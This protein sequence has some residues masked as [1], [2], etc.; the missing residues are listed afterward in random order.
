MSPPGP[1]LDLDRPGLEGNLV[2]DGQFRD[3]AG[4]LSATYSDGLYL[5][6]AAPPGLTEAKSFAGTLDAGGD[7]D[8]FTVDLAAGDLLTVKVRAKPAT[9]GADFR[10]DVDLFAPDGTKAVSG[11][12]PAALA[13]PGILKFP[14]PA[15]GTHWVVLRPGGAARAEGGTYALTIKVS[16]PKENRRRRGAT[17]P[18]GDPPVASAPFD[19]V[20]SFTLR[21]TVRGA[22]LGEIELLAPDGGTVPVPS[23]VSSGGTKRKILPLVLAGGTGTYTLRV[24]ST[25]FVVYDLTLKP[26]KRVKME[27]TP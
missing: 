26:P 2:A 10:A 7:F 20:E 27:E 23:V 4:N 15:T 9:R 24:P 18:A 8:A 17:E 6:E 1:T 16:P 13:K 3:G 14:A 12:W 19:A 25:A 11:R 5:V 22:A 21:G